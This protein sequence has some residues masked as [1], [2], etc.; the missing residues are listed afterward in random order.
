MISHGWFNQE[1]Q[2][3]PGREL[4]RFE[5]KFVLEAYMASHSQLLL[6][7]HRRFEHAEEDGGPDPGPLTRV[8]VLFKP[9]GPLKLRGHW[10]GLIVRCATANEAASVL[11]E[12]R[13]LIMHNGDRVFMLESL[14]ADQDETS[15]NKDHV[16]AMAV[17][18]HEDERLDPVS[19]FAGLD[20]APPVDGG[21]SPRPDR[22][23]WHRHP[24]GMG[25]R[26]GIGDPIAS[27]EDLIHAVVSSAS[28]QATDRGRYRQIHV[29]MRRNT[30][31]G[32]TPIERAEAAFLTL[33][34]AEQYASADHRYDE[35]ERWVEAIPIAL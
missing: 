22:A 25:L 30:Y 26:R 17:G 27:V 13:G 1:H 35:A 11:A 19:H 29:V 7:S 9:V 20:P 28:G 21:T 31:L 5:R 10:N 4:F 18:W 3:A 24:L 15:G 8:D 23:P 6:I 16:I 32:Q 2:F 33:E 34:E 14:A 12:H